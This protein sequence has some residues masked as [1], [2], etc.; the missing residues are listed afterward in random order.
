VLHNFEE[1]DPGS[2]QCI[3]LLHKAKQAGEWELCKELARFLMALDES[4]ETLRDAMKRLE[5]E[6]PP[7]PH[8]NGR[9][10]HTGGSSLRDYQLSPANDGDSLRTSSGGRSP[11]SL[12][13]SESETS[14]RNEYFSR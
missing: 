10:Q 11:A 9:F 7:T 1:L 8:I 5:M 4:G 13:T 2:Q 14:N 6:P 3:R 12:S